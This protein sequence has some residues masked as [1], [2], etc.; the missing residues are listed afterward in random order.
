M[1]YPRPLPGGRRLASAHGLARRSRPSSSSRSETYSKGSREPRRANAERSRSKSVRPLASQATPSPLI[2]TDDAGSERCAPPVFARSEFDR[3]VARAV[4]FDLAM[5]GGGP[6]SKA[7]LYP[8]PLR[9]RQW[10]PQVGPTRK[11]TTYVKLV[12]SFGPPRIAI[13]AGSQMEL[14]GWG[15]GIVDSCLCYGNF[16]HFL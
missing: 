7:G 15:N 6:K 2:V 12:P 8:L 9:G 3:R 14:G 16:A 5:H 11:R 10:R 13:A 1:C 4:L